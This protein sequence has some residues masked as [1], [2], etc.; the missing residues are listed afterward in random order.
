MTQPFW[1]RI[2]LHRGELCAW[3]LY[4]WA[5]SA[6]FTVIITAV[7]P[8]FYSQVVAAGL[9]PAA[10]RESFA[11]ATTW[12][13]LGAALAAPLLGALADVSGRKKR[14]LAAFLALGVLSTA[15]M[16]WLGPGDVRLAQWLFGLA[17]FGAAGSFV[18]YDALLVHVA[19]DSERDGLSSSAY[20]LGYL[21]GGLALLVCVLLLQH[22]PEGWDTGLATRAGFVLVAL[23]WGLFALPL[24]LMVSEPPRRL[25]ADEQAGMSVFVRSFT[26]MGETFRELRRWRAAFLMMLAFLIYNDGIG[27]II[28]MAVTFGEEKN[29]SAQTMLAVILTVQFVGIPCAILF[30]L[31]AGRIGAKRAILLA[32]GV[33]IA[34]AIYAAQLSSEREFWIMALGV[35][36]VQGGAQSLSRSLFARLIPAHKSGE[37][38]GLFATLEKFAGVLGPYLFVILPTSEGAILAL[39]VLFAGGALL[40]TR[41][42]VEQGASLAREAEQGLHQEAR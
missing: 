39:I 11:L 31:L 41:V 37:F 21:G 5:N 17:N 29:I 13:L 33:Y 27:T 35:A 18:F 6:F 40:L 34:I 20:A 22:P 10:R 19:R 30:G 1:R 9:E 24:L 4:D 2:A 38:F 15:G 7:F 14:F 8:I 16:F 23:W 36:A 12:S 32:L 25:E 28:R 42:D 3:A 26:R